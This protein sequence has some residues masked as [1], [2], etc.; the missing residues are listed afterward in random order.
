MRQN[1]DLTGS[2]HTKRGGI[3][4]VV[5]TAAKCGRGRGRKTACDRDIYVD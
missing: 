4:A 2:D 1:K 5:N 3:V